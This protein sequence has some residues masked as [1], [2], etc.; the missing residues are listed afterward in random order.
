M[1]TP[2]TDE[3]VPADGGCLD[4]GRRQNGASGCSRAIGGTHLDKTPWIQTFP[5]RAR[6][7]LLAPT[8]TKSGSATISVPTSTATT[9][10]RLPGSSARCRTRPARPR[11]IWAADTAI[12]PPDSRGAIY[13][14]R[15]PIS[16]RRPW[17]T[18]ARP[19][20]R[21]GI[22]ERVSLQQADATQL[23]FADASFDNVVMWGVLMHIPEAEKALDQVAR[24]LKPGGKFVLAE[25]NARSLDVVI[26]ER[27]VN[28]ARRAI[29]RTTHPCRRA[30]LGIEEWQ[31]A[32]SGGLMVRKT[33]I[34]ALVEFCATS[35]PRAGEALRRAIHRGA[36]ADADARFEAR[37]P[38]LQP[39]LL[40]ARRASRAVAGQYPC[41]PQARSEA[42]TGFGSIR[43]TDWLQ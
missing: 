30:P 22:S 12:T 26:L 37:H 1:A 21:A 4:T 42:L 34:P 18:L 35:R 10:R 28:L 23:P 3:S 8:S 25:N 2:W 27:L 32:E 33:D 39:V 24:V 13:R 15:L 17:R 40:Q 7:A 5:S 36:C 38:R 43:P 11:W 31:S 41:F 29:G 6:R 19:C 20:A 9:T 14:S 16:P